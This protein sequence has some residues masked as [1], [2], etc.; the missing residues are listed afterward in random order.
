MIGETVYHYRILDKIGEGGMGV[1]YR[2]EDIKLRRIVALKFLSPTSVFHGPTRERILKEARAAAS[3][4]HQN[5]CAIHEVEELDDKLFIVMAFC[6]GST[7]GD[8]IRDERPELEKSLNI[9]IQ[10]A[11]GLGAAHEVGIIHR[12]IKPANVIVSD[13][14]KVKIMDFGLAKLSCVETMSMTM[15]GAGTLGYMSP[16]QVRSDHVDPRS[17]IWSLGVLMYQMLTGR[18]PFEG[19]YDASVL[20]SIVNEPHKSAVEISP[21]IP[22]EANAIVERALRKSPDDRYETMEQMRNDIILVRNLLFGDPETVMA[23]KGFFPGARH[24]LGWK[25]TSVLALTV[26]AVLFF[27]IFRYLIAGGNQDSV[28][29]VGSELVADAGSSGPE[30]P[31]KADILYQRGRTLYNTGN[32]PK[33]ILLIEQALEMDPEHFES[34][35]TL[36]VYYSWGRD[37]KKATELASRARKVAIRRDSA[38]DLILCAAVEASVEHDWEKAAARYSDWYEVNPEEVSTPIHIGYIRSKYLGDYEGAMEQLELFFEIDPDNV[39][40][41]HGQAYNYIGTVFLYT[42]HFD[43]AMKAYEKYQ[44]LAPDTPDPVTSMAK[45]N[46]FVGHYNTAYRLYFSLL[47]LDD[48]PFTAYEGL[49]N[50]CIEMGHLRE[51][52]EHYHRYLGSSSFMGQKVNGHVHIARIYFIQKNKESFEREISRIEE[53][54]FESIRACWLRGV[55][56]IT[57]ENEIVKARGELKKMTTL[58]EK[59]SISTEYSRREHLRGLILLSEGWN[60]SALNALKEAARNSPREFFFFG[61]EYARALLQVGKTDEAIA[62][63]LDL[64]KYNANDPQLLMILC[65]ANTLNGDMVSAKE[66]YARVLEVLAGADEDFVPLIEFQAEFK[67]QTSM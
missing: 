59:S 1:V 64:A 60:M 63:C 40:G 52:N 20:Y 30:S 19:D 13:K 54:D 49:G 17:D 53:L 5:I 50:T 65:R 22:P 36:A 47:S 61:R 4:D 2:A 42:G 55:K 62:E 11:D 9:L 56:F 33:G 46:L 51:A 32:Q 16:E 35:K 66:Y 44:A 39:S 3:L 31:S 28:D 21:D 48:P 27:F 18:R 58:M 15:A 43:K 6:E 7:L 29:P 26:S 12:D 67:E 37:S 57:L 38:K 14:G 45:A 34:L 24:I 41:R 10:I 23:W 8:L 25:L